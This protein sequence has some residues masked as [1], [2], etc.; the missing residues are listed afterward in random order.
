VRVGCDGEPALRPGVANLGCNPTFGLLR[1]RLE[2]HLFDFDGDL[3]GRT[4]RVAFVERLRGEERFSSVDAL[5]A[6]I[7]S[8]AERA[9]RILAD[10]S[11][12]G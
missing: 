6:Q 8:D 4:L 9:R 2:V 11:E 1:R 12:P 3:Y 5:V 10:A 7:G